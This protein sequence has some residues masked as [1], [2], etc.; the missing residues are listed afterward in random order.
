MAKMRYFVNRQKCRRVNDYL[1][2]ELLGVLASFV[3]KKQDFVAHVD[4]TV[5][6]VGGN[7]GWVL[8]DAKVVIQ[9]PFFFDNE[10]E[11]DSSKHT[12]IH[13]TH[14]KVFVLCIINN[15]A[16]AFVDLQILRTFIA[17]LEATLFL[18]TQ[19]TKTNARW[20]R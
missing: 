6:F 19:H 10:L 20:R 8:C 12:Q 2:M 11:I 7:W 4:S 9:R 15:P 5:L 13:A 18:V 16:S 17:P 14:E 1:F 3:E